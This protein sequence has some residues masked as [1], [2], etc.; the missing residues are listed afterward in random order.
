MSPAITI[1]PIIPV[2]LVFLPPFIFVLSL[3]IVF[4]LLFLFH[5]VFVVMVFL[6]NKADAVALIF[7]RRVGKG[8]PS[9]VQKSG[10]LRQLC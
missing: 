10:R 1:I 6:F 4:V 8:F 7:E 5:P 9:V 2:F 3:F